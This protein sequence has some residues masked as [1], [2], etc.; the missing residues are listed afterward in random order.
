LALRIDRGSIADGNVDAIRLYKR[1]GF[2]PTWMY[3]SRFAGR[4]AFCG[5]A[6]PRTAKS[7]DILCDLA[8]DQEAW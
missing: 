8:H 2:R 4:Y 7:A 5:G 3:L 1:R 6:R